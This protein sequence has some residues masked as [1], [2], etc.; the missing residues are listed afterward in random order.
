MKYSDSDISILKNIWEKYPKID[1]TVSGSNI[2]FGERISIN[3]C[4]ELKEFV[5]CFFDLK[6]RVYGALSILH[7]PLGPHPDFGNNYKFITEENKTKLRTTYSVLET[8]AN[9]PM[10]TFIFHEKADH[11]I[12]ENTLKSINTIQPLSDIPLKERDYY[13]K[14]LNH[15]KHK[16]IQNMGL[17]LKEMIPLSVGNIVSW[18]SESIHCG[19]SFDSCGATYKFQLNV[20]SEEYIC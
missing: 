9:K 17:T 10:H 2:V 8:D 7:R 15:V 4:P 14:Y 19:Q 1:Y 12:W 16:D 5:S 18:D 3:S 6:L 11:N 20:I 13:K